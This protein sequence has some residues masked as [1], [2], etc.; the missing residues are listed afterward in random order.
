MKRSDS[1]NCKHIVDPSLLSPSHESGSASPAIPAPSRSPSCPLAL[2]AG[3]HLP[4]IL[5][6]ALTSL[7]VLALDL[8]SK[9]LAF[10]YVAHQP[11]KLGPP[12]PY[13]DPGSRSTSDAAQH[14]PINQP[15]LINQFEGGRQIIPFILNTRLTA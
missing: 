9:S 8:A 3:R 14:V 6:F 13:P 15:S 5:T 1:G 4:S 2:Q 11:V 10:H 7:F 12:E